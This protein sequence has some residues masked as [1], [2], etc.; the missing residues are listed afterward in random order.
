MI[1]RRTF[2]GLVAVGAQLAIVAGLSIAGATSAQ[3]TTPLAVDVQCESF[4]HSKIR[5]Q[6]I[7]T[8]G[9]GT[10]STRW[11]YNGNELPSIDNRT[12]FT[13]SCSTAKANN[14][15][16]VVTDLTG[17]TATDVGTAKCFTGNP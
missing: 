8:G 15:S 3:A 14:Y 12:A 9:V 6:R 16:A 17:A 10:V 2:R 1:K 11:S 4:G 5:C 13:F 7:V